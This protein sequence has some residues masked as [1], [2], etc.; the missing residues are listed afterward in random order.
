MFKYE[1]EHQCEKASGEDSQSINDMAQLMISNV[2][3]QLANLV[4]MNSDTIST[5]IPMTT[6]K[7]CSRV[8][9]KFAS[10]TRT[11]LRDFE[12]RI[13]SKMTCRSSI[14]CRSICEICK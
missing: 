13:V 12:H 11:G 1:C 3:Q 5:V 2:F 6:N 14:V 7:S 9:T 8:K 10:F 4:L